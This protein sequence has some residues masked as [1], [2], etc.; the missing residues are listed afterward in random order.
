M[1]SQVSCIVPRCQNGSRGL[2]KA[3]Y[4]ARTCA[5]EEAWRGKSLGPIH[6]R[7]KACT[8]VLAAGMRWRPQLNSLK[9][10]DAACAINPPKSVMRKFPKRYKAFLRGTS[11]RRSHNGESAAGI[12]GSSLSRRSKSWSM[13]KLLS[14]SCAFRSLP[15]TWR[16]SSKADTRALS[17]AKLML[18]ALVEGR[19]ARLVALPSALA[20]AFISSLPRNCSMSSS[21]TLSS[22]MEAQ[23]RRVGPPIMPIGAGASTAH[24]AS[25]TWP[26]TSGEAGTSNHGSKSGNL[27][28]PS[29]SPPLG[30]LVHTLRRP[31]YVTQTRDW[32][33]EA[34]KSNN[35]L[36]Q[37][38]TPVAGSQR[39]DRFC[40]L[41]PRTSLTVKGPFLREPDSTITAWPKESIH[42]PAKD[43]GVGPA[44]PTH[45]GISGVDHSSDPSSLALPFP[46][47]PRPFPRRRA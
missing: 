16:A 21:S 5:M 10:G 31:S 18:L 42:S 1:G 38:Q 24:A 26:L 8:S 40:S 34:A 7:N 33:P 4:N 17:A 45:G 14:N 37:A 43:E 27:T 46:P 9:S 13:S 3:R 29:A 47:H 2:S 19:V 41:S 39:N 11:G 25:S 36:P 44:C 6:R 15:K 23:R 12:M 30:H 32:G 20:L 35:A 28:T 22:A